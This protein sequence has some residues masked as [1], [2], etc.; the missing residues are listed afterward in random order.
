MGLLKLMKARGDD[1]IISNQGS[2]VG[3]SYYFLFF[4]FDSLT[5]CINLSS[6]PSLKGS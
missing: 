6:K 4:N 1:L 2:Y 5:I 3:K